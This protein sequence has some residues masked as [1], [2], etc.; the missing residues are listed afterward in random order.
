MVKDRKNV[1]D[2]IY[3][4]IKENFLSGKLDFGDSIVESDYCKKYNISKTPLREAIK[5]LEIE[6]IVERYPNG[7]MGIMDIDEESI[8]EIIEI[9][10][11]LENLIFKKIIKDG[12]IDEITKKLNQNLK[13]TEFY[14][15]SCNLDEARKLFENFNEILYKFSGLKFTTKILK[16]YTFI[17]SKLR[18]NSLKNEKRVRKAFG[19]HKL[20]VKYL[21]E[22][23][24]GKLS[25]L[26]TNHLLA[27]KESI[28]KYFREKQN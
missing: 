8:E 9:R 12:K 23:N 4:V 17:L 15:E 13:L 25:E 6:G 2:S 27:S 5:K 7:R 11:S 16:N 3:E 20:L 19:E 28:L 18:N 21:E 22:N 24:L 1:S 10:I 14:I 26:N